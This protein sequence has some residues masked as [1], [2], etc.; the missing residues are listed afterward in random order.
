VYGCPFI[1]RFKIGGR[2]MNVKKEKVYQL[3]IMKKKVEPLTSFHKLPVDVQESYNLSLENAVISA[4]ENRI[5]KYPLSKEEIIVRYITP[6]FIDGITKHM[7]NKAKYGVKW[8]KYKFELDDFDYEQYIIDYV[9]NCFHSVGKLEDAKEFE[10][11]KRQEMQQKIKM[12]RKQYQEFQL[13]MDF[14][15]YKDNN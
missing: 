1:R 12:K 10:E 9:I 13:A 5:S 15:D 8:S 4:I 7:Y 3:P 14:D 6:D 2:K 11:K